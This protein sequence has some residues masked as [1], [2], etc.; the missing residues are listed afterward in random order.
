M[1]PRDGAASGRLALPGLD[2]RMMLDGA[3]AAA[4]GTGGSLWSTAR[5]GSSATLPLFDIR[6]E[7]PVH[8]Q[9]V[10]ERAAVLLGPLSAT[11]RAAVV[12][13]VELAKRLHGVVA[14]GD[15]LSAENSAPVVPRD[16][17]AAA[18]FLRRPALLPPA[19]IEAAAMALQAAAPA[20]TEAELAAGLVRMLGLEPSAAPALEARVAALVGS[21]KIRLPG[22]S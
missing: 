6:I 9:A 5:F 3:L 12:Q 2:L 4:P 21:G 16:R 11:D 19:E 22:A 7:A 20:A 1:L 8:L 13:G 15:V 17:R 14:Q 10:V 18:A